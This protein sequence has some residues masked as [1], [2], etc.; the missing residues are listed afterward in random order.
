MP[1]E[2]PRRPRCLQHSEPG[3]PQVA[4]LTQVPEMRPGTAVPAALPERA[5]PE[6]ALVVTALVVTALPGALLVMAA[7]AALRKQMPGQAQ[8]AGFAPGSEQPQHSV[9]TGPLRP[10]QRDR[11]PHVPRRAN[12]WWTPAVLRWHRA[13]QLRWMV[14]ERQGL[15]PQGPAPLLRAQLQVWEKP[16]GPGPTE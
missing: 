15:K 4:A 6:T 9:Q 16:W 3:Q 11:K 8:A 1:G 10:G 5:S 12:R 7:S 13:D 2:G 14:R